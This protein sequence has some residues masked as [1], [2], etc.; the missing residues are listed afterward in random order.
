VDQ[1]RLRAVY[2]ARATEKRSADRAAVRG[3]HVCRYCKGALV[4]KALQARRCDDCFAKQ[5]LT[6]KLGLARRLYAEQPEKFR[7]KA[8]NYRREL[9][10]VVV[11]RTRDWRAKNHEWLLARRREQ[12]AADPLPQRERARLCAAKRRAAKRRAPITIVTR[13]DWELCKEVFGHRCAYCFAAAP[14][15]LDHVEPLSR[16]GA[17]AMSNIVPA[18]KPCNTRKNARTL[19]ELV[20][21]GAI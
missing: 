4:G 16:G 21:R 15:T 5:E 17:H 20:M 3:E 8:R 1:A 12:H 7:Q 18:C 6:R 9:G 13:A 19:L 14:L 2:A 11:Q 10:D